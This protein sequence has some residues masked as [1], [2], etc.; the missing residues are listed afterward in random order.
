MPKP[1]TVFKSQDSRWVWHCTEKSIAKGQISILAVAEIFIAILLYWWLASYF[2]WPW[3]T[4]FG[5]IGAPMLLLRSEKSVGLGIKL[6]RQYWEGRNERF[7]KKEIWQIALASTLVTGLTLYGVASQWLLGHSGWSLSWRAAV[8]FMVAI[9]VAVSMV[10]AFTVAFATGFASAMAFSV[11]FTG[12]GAVVVAFAGAVAVSFA[13]A[14]SDS[15]NNGQTVIIL[16][17][18]I[19]MLLFVPFLPIGIMLRGFAIRLFATLRHPLE[20]LAQLPQNWRESML[21]IDFLQAPE[22]LPCAGTIDS[23]LTVTGL[24]S[25]RQKYFHVEKIFIGV[26]LLALYIPAIIYRL[27][28]KASAWLWFPLAL[29]LSPPAYQHD[30][31]NAEKLP[32]IALP[33]HWQ[34]IVLASLVMLWLLASLPFSNPWQQLLP[35]EL[36]AI[37]HSTPLGLRTLSACVI[38]VFAALLV[39]YN[40]QLETGRKKIV[41]T[42]AKQVGQ[43]LQKVQRLTRIRMLLISSIILWGYAMAIAILHRQY[44]KVVD[45]YIWPWL[46]EIL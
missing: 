5:M 8:L 17:S 32:E 23:D 45:G 20:G 24:W 37:A 3:M 7:S 29:S 38:T 4:F 22:L 30:T 27:S 6:L 19:A 9:A 43:F 2:H 34:Y 40:I 36:K 21:T 16:V 1:N 26:L 42:N 11:K 18:A 10:S 35:Q 15:N 25:T 33:Q 46:L 41:P 13:V 31:Q 44:P 14:G 39:I 12:P 28:L